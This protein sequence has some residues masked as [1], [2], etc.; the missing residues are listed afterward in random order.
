MQFKCTP[1]RS[2]TDSTICSSGLFNLPVIDIDTSITTLS[3][4]MKHGIHVAVL[5][6]R[7][8]YYSNIRNSNI[9]N[10]V[11]ATDPPTPQVTLHDRDIKAAG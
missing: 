9:R 10:S 4:I 7:T 8:N 2:D 3:T 6:T 11:V 1:R 5:T